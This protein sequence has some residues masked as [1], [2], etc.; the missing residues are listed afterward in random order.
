M[1]THTFPIIIDKQ[2]TVF[3]SPSISKFLRRQKTKLPLN[4]FEAQN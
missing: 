1:N 4:L 2:T 3:L